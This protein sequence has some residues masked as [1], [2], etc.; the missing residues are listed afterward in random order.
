MNK[1]VITAIIV[2]YLL[3][4]IGMAQR[5]EY[6][7]KKG[8]TL[9]PPALGYALTLTIFCTVWTFLGSIGMASEQ[10]IG[11]L[12]VYLGPTLFMP[13]IAPILLRMNRIS[14]RQHL[15]SIADFIS[16]RYGKNV[17]LGV[18]VTLFCIIG[19]VPYIAIQLK[20]VSAC[21][22]LMTNYNMPS[23]L[24]IYDTTFIIAVVLTLFVMLYGIRHAD[25]TEQHPGIMSAVA[26]EGGIKLIVFLAAGLYVCFYLF[27]TPSQ[28]FQTAKAQGILTQLGRIGPGQ[29]PFNWFMISLISG[30][31]LLLLPR[32]FQVA[33][34]ENTREKNIRTAMW[35]F[36][37]YLL[38]INVFVLPIATAGRI[39]FPNT[40]DKDL[41]LL[42]LPFEQGHNGLTMLL[43]I[44]CVSAATGMVMVELIAL[45]TM[46][47][48]HVVMPILVSGS[49]IQQS[50]YSPARILL[51]SRRLGVVVLMALAYIFEKKVAEHYSL[52]SV[53][54]ISFVAVS[55]F[56]PA[57]LVGMYWPNATRKAAVT[58]ILCGFMV[59][60][61]TLIIPSLAEQ[62]NVFAEWQTHGL[63]HWAWLI[64]Q[65]LFQL[66]IGSPIAHAAFWSLLLNTACVFG[67]SLV[68]KHS[69]I[70]R[71][72]AIL[73]T[74]KKSG[75]QV[76][77][78]TKT[79]YTEL[80]RLLARFIGD[81]RAQVLLE[82]YANRH[83]IPFTT[84]GEA[85]SRML[86][87]SE[88][89]LGGTIG[90]ASARL[91]LAGF[92]REKE[93][94]FHEVETIVRESQQIIELNKE[95]RKKSIELEK[96]SNQL[97][98][99]NTQLIKMDELKND[100]LNTVTHELRTPLT[101]IRALS[102]I[103]HDNPDLSTQEQQEYLSIIVQ[104]TE[105]LSHLINQVLRLEKFESGRQSLH[106]NQVY[107][108]ALIHDVIRSLSPLI[109]QRHL[110]YSVQSSESKESIQ[111]DVDLIRQVLYNL[112]SNA[113]RFAQTTIII[114]VQQQP[115]TLT[116][117]IIDDGPGIPLEFANNLFDKFYQV[118]QRQGQKPEGSGLGL[119][120]CKKI[121]EL[122]GGEIK[123]EITQERGACFTFVLPQPV[124][125]SL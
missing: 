13:L 119:A 49:R 116:A 2:L 86:S 65:Q 83:Q 67:L 32:Q 28:L 3:S 58:G 35:L 12:P 77:L 75:A 4:L 10:G 53:G 57:L 25:A 91:M 87:F 107:F 41:M 43:F 56:A 60:F 84:G 122:H 30:L 110:E 19:I 121:I 80:H 59:W 124:T 7:H 92:T 104:E 1:L 42:Q 14:H 102:E 44:G 106:V 55:Q 62:F 93:V 15:T 114:R 38:L 98:E 31:S 40:A 22:N 5:A 78:E 47:S 74:Q 101:S 17:S 112:L 23:S 120:I 123:L 34:V 8:K 109:E 27:Q 51:F 89:I 99:M 21:I 76:I 72:Q 6:L 103:V 11:F 71:V 9:L 46:I 111:L 125:P 63:F 18:I 20:A 36:P 54:L 24:L 100:F 96:A 45:T 118:K 69:D 16:S 115:N 37:L 66:N 105:K 73:F 50:V 90:A 97:S 52:V 108:T 29:S 88:R 39:Y 85:D 94:R 64:P 117:S 113:I 33:V 79:T 68:T 48:N 70:E 95:L 26:V 81:D 82:G 61:Y